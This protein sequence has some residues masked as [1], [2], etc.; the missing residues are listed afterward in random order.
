MRDILEV[1]RLVLVLES[2]VDCDTKVQQIK[3][4]RDNGDI[5]PDEAL[6]LALE[7]FG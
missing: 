5:T 6:E 1:A 7:Y 4:V 3:L 2:D